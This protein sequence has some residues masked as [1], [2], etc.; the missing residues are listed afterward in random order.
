MVNFV[1]EPRETTDHCQSI[2]DAV[3]SVII[4]K[5][6]I[7]EKILLA[8]LCGGHVLLEDVPGVGKT[9]LAK[10]FA[11][12]LDCSFKRVQFMPDLLPS[13]ITGSVVYNLKTTDFTFRPGP[14]FAN[15]VLADEINRASPKTQSSLLEC[16]DEAQ[17]TVD[18]NTHHL[19]QP[20][21]VIATQNPIEQDGV[22]RLPLSQTDRFFMNL[23]MGY[24]ALD[25]E[26]RIVEDQRISHPLNALSPVIS[27][28]DIIALQET[29]RHVHVDA[30]VQDYILAIVRTTREMEDVVYG[31]GP[32]GSLFLS[33]CAQAHAAIKGRVYVT[34]D[35]VKSIAVEILAHRI[36]LD[37][38]IQLEGITAGDIV[39]RAI[40]TTAVPDVVIVNN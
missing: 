4:G 5:T 13:D 20:F 6:D 15:V 18:G 31:A 9:T 3:E 33:R 40:E 30:L 17:V 22:F 25:E 39:Q 8:L 2:I 12:V 29:V 10:A 1:M 19:P 28:N 16:M 24:P 26:R 27:R 37:P 32:R 35:D 14:I 34:P 38:A 11:R 36:L 21:T 23:K 7:V